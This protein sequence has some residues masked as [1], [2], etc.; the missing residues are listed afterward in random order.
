M[1]MTFYW[2]TEGVFSTA[3]AAPYAEWVGMQLLKVGDQLVDDVLAALDQ[4]ISQDN[5]IWPRLLAPFFLQ[6]PYLLHGLGLIPG[7]TSLPLTMRAADGATHAVTLPAEIRPILYFFGAN[8]PESWAT[9]P[10]QAPGEP[11]L[12]LQDAG[13]YWF[14]YLPQHKTVYFQFK[15]VREEPDEPFEQFCGR[16]FA[17]IDDNDVEK[18][19][20]D[21]RRNSGGNTFLH[22]PFLMGL[23]QSAKINQRGKL[24]VIIGRNTFSAA[25]NGATMIEEYTNAIFVGEPTGA[26]PNFVGETTLV[27]LPYSQ[28]DISISD[29]YWQTSWPMDHRKWI[30]P[31]LYAPPSFAAYA[32]NRDPA[33]EAILAY[34]SIDH[35]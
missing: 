33:L 11:P 28:L 27:T 34:H 7:P 25:M 24:F 20:I 4:I 8:P 30:A 31:L 12:Y 26:S 3:S 13:H 18:L 19:I 32:A 5:P 16:L 9:V 22:R 35:Q 17:C 2:F 29:L 21:L 1:T 23:I 6:Q 10:Q 15:R 14:K